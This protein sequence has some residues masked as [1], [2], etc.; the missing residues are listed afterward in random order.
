M[1]SRQFPSFLVKIYIGTSVRY[2]PEVGVEFATE[3]LWQFTGNGATTFAITKEVIRNEW[4]V[5]YPEL[6]GCPLQIQCRVNIGIG[7]T[8]NYFTLM[9]IGDET[10]WRLVTRIARRRQPYILELV[11]TPLTTIHDND[12]DEFIPHESMV[13]LF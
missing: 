6:A 7:P 9:T 5:S 12:D 2:S 11:V 13:P 1:S 3:C 10:S 4:N 8:P